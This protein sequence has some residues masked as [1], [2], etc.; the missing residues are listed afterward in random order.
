MAAATITTVRFSL[1]L[2][3]FLLHPGLGDADARKEDALEIGIEA[4]DARR[5]GDAMM[6][7]TRSLRDDAAAF[8]ETADA[9]AAD[10]AAAA[11]DTEAYVERRVLAS[12]Y[13]SWACHEVGRHQE[14]LDHAS[15]VLQFEPDNARVR[16]NIRMWVL[17]D[18]T[19]LAE[20]P[21]FAKARAALKAKEWAL[22]TYHLF[23]VLSDTSDTNF[24]RT[25]A[26]LAVVHEKLSRA[27]TGLRLT[28]R[29]LRHGEIALSLDRGHNERMLR[30]LDNLRHSK[31]A[32]TDA[33][34]EST[35][36]TAA[37]AGAGA[38]EGDEL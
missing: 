24:P 34:T 17:E 6:H 33:V 38:G 5:Y 4:F 32:T 13:L 3:V 23:A 16:E 26:E 27:F 1:T 18:G 19:R 9:A 25:A 31:Q 2:L 8:E 28:S 36:A 14:A 15:V 35:E 20:N 29:A 11:A 7:L 37:G 30:T 21:H 10:D 22:A 12:D